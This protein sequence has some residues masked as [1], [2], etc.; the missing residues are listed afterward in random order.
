[1]EGN[2]SRAVGRILGIEKN[3]CLYWIHQ[4]AKQINEKEVSS[5]RLEVIEMDELYSY[6]NKKTDFM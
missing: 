6:I 2:G 5:E 1:M 3:M 4:R